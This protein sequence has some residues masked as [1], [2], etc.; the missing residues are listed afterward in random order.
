[1]KQFKWVAAAALV[2]LLGVLQ[3]CAS[4]VSR[5]SND[6]K[7]DEIVFPDIEK[8]AWLKEGTFPNIDNLRSVAPGMTKEQLYALLGRPHFREGMWGV[9]EWDYV[10]N[11]RKDGGAGVETCQYKVI[12]APDLHVRSTH[13][14]PETCADY[15]KPP[16]P[17]VQTVIERVIEKQVPVP[18]PKR[19]R[20]GADGM[21]AFD[22]SDLTD[23]RPGGIEKL[24]RV[25]ED[26]LSGD[27]IEQ[28]KVVGHTD[29]L[30]GDAYNMRLSQARAETVQR[31]LVA[32]GIPAERITSSGVGSS[33][34]LVE[35]K[36]K[37]RNDALIRC[38]E[39][40]RRVEIEAW[41]VHKP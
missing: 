32:K 37:N 10:F 41:S 25:A 35:C 2:A 20:L 21:F 29:R 8:N 11:F 5:L 40:N 17:L 31:Y 7:S 24:N 22:K 33:M 23:L 6:G 19:V 4:S 1:M 39:P 34:P 14:K 12:Y 27:E 38:L 28:V 13:W 36:Q 16:A 26:L 9:R 30:G 18:E 3:G 15:L